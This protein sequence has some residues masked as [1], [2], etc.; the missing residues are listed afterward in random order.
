MSQA[1]TDARAAVAGRGRRA[2]RTDLL[3][4][5]YVGVESITWFMLL[6]VLTTVAERAFLGALADRVRAER[7]GNEFFDAASIDRAVAVIEAA[8]AAVHGPSW[9]LVAL[10]AFGGFYL[11]RLM[12]RMGLAGA[13]GA[14]V[15]LF[16]TVLGLNVIAHLAIAGDLR[17]WDTASVA[18]FLVTPDE[19]F[20]GRVSM[21]AFI[22]HPV[23][24][25]AHGAAISVEMLGLAVVWFRFVLAGRSMVTVE[26]VTRSFGGGFAFALVAMIGAALGGVSGLAPWVVAQFVGGVLALA[27]GNH[28]RATAPSDG[29]MKP[30][31]WLV[32][33]G[34]TVGMLLAM[35]GL[36]GLAVLLNVAVVLSAVGGVAL[37]IIEIV[38]III[39]T[40]IYWVMDFFLRLLLPRGITG[41]FD[42]LARVGANF[43]QLREQQERG[44]GGFP[45]WASN[46]AKFLAALLIAWLLYRFARMLM[47]RRS[48]GEGPV[49]EVRGD[50][51]SSGGLG[52]FLRDLLP[53]GRRRRRDGWERRHPAYLLWHRAEQDG[54]E[55][56]FGRLSGETAVEFASRAEHAMAAPFPLVAR[57]FDRLRYGRHDPPAG[58]IVA[59]DAALTAW[60]VATPATPELR[61]R[62]AGAAPLPPAKDFAL[63]VEAAKRIARG[64]PAPGEERPEQ[65]PDTMI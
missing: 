3:D 64:K 27:V 18:G 12:T 38:L 32:A 37:K 31:P 55:R 40:P 36:L 54:T 56:G 57:V 52:S 15:L 11:I 42:N 61:E 25:G 62:L 59:A 13:L 33:V 22:R 51:S 49:V 30:G 9:P 28:V 39:I 19:Y 8:H 14:S 44:Q 50:A 7:N 20:S 21:G 46:G 63:R 4:V 5:L 16:A 41:I 48:S 29:P 58:E 6:R 17:L 35:A 53:R 26:R 34:G 24:S 23:V 65:P 60:E 43:D 10:T 47:T 2:W 45:D 1:F